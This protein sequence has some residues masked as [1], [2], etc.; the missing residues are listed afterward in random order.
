M[1]RGNQTATYAVGGELKQHRVLDGELQ[2][3]HWH[4]SSFL[5]VIGSGG[6]DGSFEIC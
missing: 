2:C 6:F 5:V 3:K 1:I 4:R